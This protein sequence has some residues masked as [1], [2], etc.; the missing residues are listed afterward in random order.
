MPLGGG[1]SVDEWFE[2]EILLRGIRDGVD[3]ITPEEQK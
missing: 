1:E 3:V 2:Q